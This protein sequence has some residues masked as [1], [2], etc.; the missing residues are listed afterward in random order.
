MTLN[1]NRA[2]AVLELMVYQR[3]NDKQIAAPI[4]LRLE[5]T[6][7]LSRKRQR[8]FQELTAWTF[9]VWGGW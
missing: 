1:R 5:L 7:V 9:P 6:S 4:H 2:P 3:T 8:I